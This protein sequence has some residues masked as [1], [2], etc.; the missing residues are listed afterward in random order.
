M[1]DITPVSHGQRKKIHVL[2]TS[3]KKKYFTVLVIVL[4]AALAG[5]GYCAVTSGIL[6]EEN[7]AIPLHIITR[8]NNERIAHN[9]PPVQ[10]DDNLVEQAKRTSREILISRIAYNSQ[11]SLRSDR[12]TDSVIYPKISWAV[13]TV[14]LEPPL[15]DSWIGSDKNFQSDILNK[16]YK[17][18]G[19]G[20]SGDSYN[21]FIVT[22][23]Q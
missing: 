23:W 4:L 14:H 2:G 18:I 20:M 7:P 10:V 17:K 21:Y 9:L 5:V 13:S 8:I 22:K 16:E 11:S 3:R 15:F 19:I 6:A 12:G 1:S